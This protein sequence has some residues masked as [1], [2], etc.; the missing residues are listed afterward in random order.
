MMMRGRTSSQKVRYFAVKYIE[1]KV[2][3]SMI[4]MKKYIE[5]RVRGKEGKKGIYTQEAV[6]TLIQ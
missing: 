6:I 5:E 3:A 4:M 1:E 2:E